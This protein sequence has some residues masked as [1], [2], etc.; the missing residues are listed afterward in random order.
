MND[1]IKDSW[2]RFLNPDS[3]KNNLIMGSLYITSF[4]ILKDSIIERLKDFFIE[5][6]DDNKFIYSDR[7][8][9]KV[10]S[11]HKKPLTASLMWLQNMDTINND[12]IL[13]FK[14][15][16]IFRNKLAHEMLGFLTNTQE[17]DLIELFHEMINL[18]TKIEKWW[19]INVE[20]PTDSNYDNQNINENEIIPGVNLTLKLLLD[21]ALGNDEESKLYYEEFIKRSKKYNN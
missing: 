2:E 3:L 5:G 6:I 8:K 10:L 17:E 4:E 12:D 16:T 9:T 19:I 11:L 15:I 7:Y 20:I 18:I 13:K 1:N 14:K 21:V